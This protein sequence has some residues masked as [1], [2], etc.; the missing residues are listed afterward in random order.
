MTH[1][2]YY[3]GYMWCGMEWN[4]VRSLPNTYKRFG[5]YE[6]DLFIKKIVSASKPKTDAFKNASWSDSNDLLGKTGFSFSAGGS[7]DGEKSAKD[8]KNEMM[9]FSCYNSP[10]SQMFILFSVCVC[11]KIYWLIM[12]GDS[13]TTLYIVKITVS[14]FTGKLIIR[15]DHYAIMPQY[16][17]HEIR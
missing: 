13:C 16:H 2:A 10:F 15:V 9:A 11:R 8:Y 17:K 1:S 7:E 12:L 6:K 3:H 4:Q 14:R 5:F